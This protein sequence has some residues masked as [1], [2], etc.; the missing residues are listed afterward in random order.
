MGFFHVGQAGLELLTSGD[1]PTSASQ[2]ARITVESHRARPEK[3]N[4]FKIRHDG[5][6]LCHQAG[7]QWRDLGSLQPPPSGFK[8]FSCL[9]L[10]SSWN[11]RC[12]PPHPANF[13]IFNRDRVSPCWPGWS[14]SLDLVI[15]LP[16]P[17][18][19]LGLQTRSHRVAQ[20]GL[21]LPTSDDL[22]PLSLQ[23]L[24]GLNL[25]YLSPGL[26]QKLPDWIHSIRVERSFKNI[27][28]GWAWWITSIIPAI[29]EAEADGSPENL[30]LSPRLE[31]S[32][33]ISAHCNLCLPG[34]SNSPA[35]ASQVAG[36]PGAYH[37]AWLTFVFSVEMGFH[38]VGQA[39]L[40]LLT[41]MIRLPWPPEVAGITGVSHQA[42][43]YTHVGRLRWED[44]WHPGV[45]D[46][47][48]QHSKILS[49]QKV[50]KNSQIGF[51][52]IGQAGL[53]LL[54]SGNLPTS[55]SQSAGITGALAFT[56]ILK[57]DN[58]LE[59]ETD[60][61]I[62]SLHIKLGLDEVKLCFLDHT[63]SCLEAQ[64]V[65]LHQLPTFKKPKKVL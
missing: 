28:L 1:S 4:F 55:A 56:L 54:A 10:L 46:Q 38:H 35:S 8:Q 26:V 36:T 63:A 50:K 43:P 13:C 57:S 29:W 20:A 42:W 23:N 31:C 9:S 7:V 62:S 47:P 41:L 37:H 49:L 2:S 16:W 27:K 3:N 64:Q 22:P 48:G 17:P 6:S 59:D 32:G 5:V 33:T 58:N 24:L 14:R 65:L 52:H 30:A 60:T 18:K 40:E 39:G 15:R 61:L 53:E 19:V 51:H 12:T 45:H 11:Y 44:H 21:E 34:S 25:H